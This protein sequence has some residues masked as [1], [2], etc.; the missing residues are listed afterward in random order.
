M[1]MIDLYKINR[2]MKNFLTIF[3][4]L[5]FAST[6]AF[7]PTAPYDSTN[8]PVLLSKQFTFTEGASV[9]KKGN[10]FFTDQPNN[11]IWEYDTN[12]KLSVFLDNAGRANGMYFDAKGNLIVCADEHNQLWS[13]SPKKK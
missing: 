12:G 8:K 6:E 13:V 4:L 2:K 10:V 11:K 7:S 3:V 1:A 5:A 9:D